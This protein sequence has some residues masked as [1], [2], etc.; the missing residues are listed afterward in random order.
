[1]AWNG[2]FALDG[3]EFI[4]VERTEAYAAEMGWFR[5]TFGNTDLHVVLDHD[6][7]TD[8]VTD[9]APWFDPLVTESA[10]FF[11]IY[12]LDVSGIE[13]SS[14]GSTVIESTIDGAI[15]G[16][17]R[18]ASKAV[19]FSVLL[20]ARNEKGAAYGAQ[21]LRR[22]LLG[23]ACEGT[24]DLGLGKD[25][26]FLSTEPDVGLTDSGEAERSLTERTLRRFV[27]NVGPT[28]TAQ[29]SMATCEG[30]MWS[31]GFTGVA[32]DPHM[33]ARSKPIITGWLDA[34]PA[35]AT[36][37]NLQ[38]HSSFED[39]TSGWTVNGPG[40]LTFE[41]VPDPPSGATVAR[42][43][44]TG[45]ANPYFTS[46]NDSFLIPIAP[47]D[48]GQ[49]LT[50][51]AM[52]RWI[53]EN[54]PNPLTRFNVYFLD[55]AKATVAGGAFIGTP[56]APDTEWQRVQNNDNQIPVGSVWAQLRPI[57][58]TSVTGDG[59]EVDSLFATIGANIV[60]DGPHPPYVPHEGEVTTNLNP[61]A[62]EAVPGD[63]D[64]LP[65]PFAEVE[66]G[67]DTWTP[68]YDP[69]CPPL[70][71]PPAPPSLSVG[72][73]VIP[74]TW[75]RRTA[76]LEA[77]NVPL[78]GA[79]APVIRIYAPELLRNVRFRFYADPTEDLDPDATPCAFV[80]DLVV[81][82][83]PAEAVM[84]IDTAVEEVWVETV[85][86]QQ[87]RADRLVVST[88]GRPIDW[89]V[90]TCGQQYLFVVDIEP[91]VTPPTID[92]SMTPRIV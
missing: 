88:Q 28:V 66:C 25:L 10:D 74:E 37:P 26:T 49:Y 78:W 44:A 14:R 84:V 2:Y 92:L 62:P 77:E 59:I 55:A 21:W 91:G 23:D 31:I 5:P 53:G 50:A 69:L 79:M 65:T 29:R 43:V 90:L 30:E 75:D 71:E 54:D 17:V 52:Y 68:I 46:T 48:I 81:S 1:M 89:P 16:R 73:L 72:C 58:N 12:P 20:L 45:A 61:W 80:A 63:I 18:H 38:P 64:I 9:A 42:F 60:N 40:T 24:T 56:F 8:P 6:P 76:V 27:I 15:P 39:D 57:I 7:Y 33:Y 13:D 51:Y 3:R 36:I 83:L 22:T 4:N 47:G 87:R 41:T 34:T 70:I 11:G 67:D 35:S 32:G 85:A 82:Y 19:V 86:G